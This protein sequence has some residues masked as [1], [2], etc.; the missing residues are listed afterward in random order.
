VSV[1]VASD[2]KMCHNLHSW[3]LISNNKLSDAV[4]SDEVAKIEWK[5]LW[6]ALHCDAKNKLSD[7]VV[8]DDVT[9]IEWKENYKKF[10]I[11]MLKTNYQMRLY[12][13]MLLK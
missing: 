10:S 13:K 3:I 6:E 5:K 8:S 1:D 4:V 7:A 11:V 9:E 12:R 2:N